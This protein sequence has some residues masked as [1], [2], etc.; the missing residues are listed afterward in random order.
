M[1]ESVLLLVKGLPMGSQFR[2][3]LLQEQRLCLADL[4]SST[5][6]KATTLEYKAV[7]IHHLT[8]ITLPPAPQNVH[9]H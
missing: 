5:A 9:C 1:V 4:I 6:Y 3:Q 7:H 8:L 2:I